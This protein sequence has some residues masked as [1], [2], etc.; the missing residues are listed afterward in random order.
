MLFLLIALLFGGAANAEISADPL[1]ELAHSRQWARLLHYKSR[2]FGASASS[3]DGQEFFFSPDGR[4]DPAAELRASLAAF[5]KGGGS[6]GRLK[7]TAYCAFPARRRFLEEQ[8]GRKFPEEKCEKKQEWLARLNPE[9]ISL[10]FATS[11]PGNPAS[12]FGHSFLKVRQKSGGEILDWSL[13]YAAMVPEDENGFAFAWFGLT[14]GYVGQ[15]ALVPYYAKIEE[16]NHSEGRDLWE[17]DLGLSRE[18]SLLL[19]D[20]VWELETNS[21]FDYYF[22]DENCSY[23]V[24]TLLEIARPDWELSSY[25][26]HQIPGDT[27]RKVA[28]QP[29]AVKAVRMR[30]SLDRRLR[31]TV[32]ALT[33]EER[34]AFDQARAGGGLASLPLASMDAYAL[35]LQAEKQRKKQKWNV[36]DEARFR[37]VLSARA[38]APKAAPK[39]LEFG[40]ERTRPELSH[41]S[42]RVGIGPSLTSRVGSARVGADFDLHFA[43]HDLLDPDPGYMPHSEFMWPNFRFRYLNGKFTLEKAELFSMVSLSPWNLVRRPMAWRAQLAYLRIPDLNERGMR[44]EGGPGAA[45]A[46]LPERWTVWSMVGARAEVA[47]ALSSTA[48]FQAW[49]EVASLYTFRGESKILLEARTLWGRTSEGPWNLELRGGLSHPFRRNWSVRVEA[50]SLLPLR[51]TSRSASDGRLLFLRYF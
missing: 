5:E 35:Y 15:F 24:L 25:F 45:W 23:Q 29:G 17:Y 44:V 28:M 34:A 37:S 1:H 11:Y 36:D 42:Y 2:W 13:N 18:E 10:V 6:Y 50:Q 27:V 39:A 31:V 49:G 26:I 30:P 19:L 51:K 3:V 4:H 12:M 40:G 21:H 47:E 14:G 7:Q 22:A 38:A 9:S 48:R 43:Y 20:A 8:L 16:Y 32:E 41:G 46:L 33:A